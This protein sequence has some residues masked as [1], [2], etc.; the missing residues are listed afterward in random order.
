MTETSTATTTKIAAP[1]PGRRQHYTSM[2]EGVK[3]M[4][5]AAAAAAAVRANPRGGASAARGS[6][7]HKVSRVAPSGAQN[8]RFY[9]VV[10]DARPTEPGN[11]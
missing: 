8:S 9:P 7:R 5:A 6:G 11:Y 4:A 3:E 10:K 1:V 2:T